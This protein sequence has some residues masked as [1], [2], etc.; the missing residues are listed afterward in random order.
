MTVA[1][2]TNDFTSHRPLIPGGCAYYRS[3]LPASVLR[4]PNAFGRP[5]FDPAHGFMV[6]EENTATA[7]KGFTTVSLKLV[8]DR[9]TPRQME[10]A[11]ALGQRIVVDIDDYYD[12]LTAANAAYDLTHP[13]KNKRT[14]RD[15]Y[16]RV[17]AQ[18]DALTVSTPFLYEY[19]SQRHPNVTLV[20]NGYN[21][22]QF[23]RMKVRPTKPVLGW[24]G[25]TRFRNSDLEQLREWLPDFLEKHD[26]LFRH[27]GHDPQGLSFAAVTGIPSKRLQVAPILPVTRYAEAFTFDIGIVPLNDIPFNHAK[28]NIKGLEYAAAGIPFVASDMPE[29]RR[30]HDDGIGLLA[31]TPE[32]WEQQLEWML[33]YDNRKYAAAVQAKRLEEWSIHARAAEWNTV[34][35]S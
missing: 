15:N 1:F 6:R 34:Y 9:W 30:L 31:T 17:I 10:L 4:T 14:N 11:Q 16:T 18:A 22:A 12:G 19:H 27:V 20:R 26:L 25:S 29:Y 33:D 24:T 32:E 7:I 35:P 21:P 23:T 5:A 28:S 13:E 2:L 3:Y 8:M